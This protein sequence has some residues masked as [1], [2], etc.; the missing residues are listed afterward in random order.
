MASKKSNSTFI[1]SWYE[2]PPKPG[3]YRSIFKWGDPEG[4]KHPNKRLFSLM[5][6]EFNLKDDYFKEPKTLGQEEV[7]FTKKPVELEESHIRTITGIVG[8]EN[9]STRDYDRLKYSSGKTMEEILELRKGIIREVT[10]LVVHPRNKEE[11]RKIVEYC[12]N[13]RIPIY[14]YGGGSTVNFGYR[15]AL[16]GITLV[17]STHMNKVVRINELNKTCTVEAGI[18]GPAYEEALNNSRDSFSTKHNYTCGHFPQSFEYSTVGGWIVTW[19]SG[20]NSSYFGDACDL[21]IAMEWITPAGSFKTHEYPATAT[22]PRLLDIMKGS[23]GTFGILV[24]ATLKIFYYQPKNRFPFSYIFP[25]W[26]EGLKAVREISQGEFGFPG[27]FRLSDPEETGV[28]LKLY[29]VEG[30]PL[31]TAMKIGGF[32]PG[33]RCLFL[34]TTEG[35]RGFARNVKRKVA[36]ICFRN[37]GM[38]LTGYP[39]RK[40]EHGRFT[41]PY[42]RED[43]DDYGIMLDTLET[44]VTWENLPRVHEEVREYIKS[45]PKTVCMAHASHFYPQGTNLYF[46]YFCRMDDPEEY[47]KFQSGVFDAILRGGGSLSHHHGVGRMI[48]PWM[49]EHLGK[50]QMAALKAL[51]KHFD[52]NNIMNPG[53]QLGLD[54]KPE[55]LPSRNWRINWKKHFGRG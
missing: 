13:F 36:G 55:E 10:D 38:T 50:E 48:A 34:G 53:G 42:M 43:L 4:F 39:A 26:E 27:V 5:K 35:E 40:W 19:G 12:N 30:T 45:R 3:S 33:K 44:A 28:A 31:D 21:V 6:Q 9:V 20:Q 46:I 41:D 52:P 8:E 32:K 16:G 1:P 47:I 11:V 49:E 37:H 14:V 24:E 2:E 25:T 54:F 18:W 15:P 51:K 22:G 7:R 17:L 29:G 23:E